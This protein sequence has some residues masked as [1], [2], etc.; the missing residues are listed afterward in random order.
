[1][2]TLSHLRKSL[3]AASCFALIAAGP[4]MFGQKAGD[5]AKGKEVFE[6]NCS[7][8]H[9]ADS[10]E[11]KMGPGLKGLFKH[12]KLSNGKKPTE[13]NVRAKIN[14]GGGGMP[15]YGDMLSDEEKDNLI[16]YLKT[17]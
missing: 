6:S 4:K 7:V 16:A 14:E 13:A 1:M 5:A 11:K 8:C 2:P 15:A 10:E 3:I 9:N 12:E 17:L